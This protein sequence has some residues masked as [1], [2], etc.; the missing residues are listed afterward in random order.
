MFVIITDKN[1]RK[2]KNK[3]KKYYFDKNGVLA[4]S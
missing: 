1:R 2:I 3:G 4:D